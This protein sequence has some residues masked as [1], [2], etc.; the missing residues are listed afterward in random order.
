MKRCASSSN[1]ILYLVFNEANT[2]FSATC[3]CNVSTKRTIVDKTNLQTS[4][5]SF[6]GGENGPKGTMRLLLLDTFV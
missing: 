5:I 4:L 3:L 1:K 6:L 2:I